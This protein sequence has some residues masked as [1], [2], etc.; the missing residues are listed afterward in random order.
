MTTNSSTSKEY[1]VVC[2]Q[3][4]QNPR[5][6]RRPL[7]RET[8]LSV[9]IDGRPFLDTTRTPVNDELLA[10][11]ILFAQGAISTVA[12][13][14]SIQV[15]TGTENAE[16]GDLVKDAMHLTLAKTSST[17]KPPAETGEGQ[18]S[19]LERTIKSPRN[20][21]FSF[22]K[23]AQLP[24][25]MTAHQE[26]YASSR[27][28]H[29]VGIFNWKGELL[30]CQ[31]DASRTHALHKALGFCLKHHVARQQTIAVFSG[32]INNA[33][34]LTI[35]RAG[36]PLVLSISAPTDSAVD[37]LSRAGVTYIGSLRDHRGVLYTPGK[38]FITITP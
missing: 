14:D 16:K 29:A 15:L 1:P 5:A 9:H 24:Q 38:E 37:I 35:V 36:F 32:R 8:P 30:S 21:T 25:I 23:L 20:E 33:I 13:I 7:I 3:N 28:A 6:D 22:R 26:L 17:A 12:E 34:A 10:I 19:G 2:F 11:G 18:K 31:E 27:A 4:G